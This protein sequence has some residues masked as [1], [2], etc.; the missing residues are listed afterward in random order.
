MR[1][2]FFELPIL[3]IHY[4]AQEVQSRQDKVQQYNENNRGTQQQQTK[5]KK[6]GQANK[7]QYTRNIK[8]RTRPPHTH[9]KPSQATL[10][11]T[12]NRS[13]SR[14]THKANMNP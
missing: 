5:E 14:P 8:T 7:K 3:L 13:D 1:I 11:A 4:K 9:A 10:N 6:G 12:Y 2:F